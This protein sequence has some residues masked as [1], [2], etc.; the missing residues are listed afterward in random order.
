[1]KMV[2]DYQNNNDD[3][4]SETFWSDHLGPIFD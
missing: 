1:M 2:T 4:G 3:D